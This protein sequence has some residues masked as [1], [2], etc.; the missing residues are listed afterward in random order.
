MSKATKMPPQ[1]S[2]PSAASP[3]PQ[4]HHPQEDPSVAQHTPLYPR[5]GRIGYVPDLKLHHD[6]QMA[7]LK[8]LQESGDVNKLPKGWPAVL[9]GPLVWSGDELQGRNDWVYELSGSDI[10]EIYSGLLHCKGT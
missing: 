1:D 4:T 10:A 3:R 2:N 6:R 9:E 5:L 7:S 8:R